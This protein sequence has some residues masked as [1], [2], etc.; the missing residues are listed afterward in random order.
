MTTSGQFS[1][2]TST[3]IVDAAVAVQVADASI[4]VVGPPCPSSCAQ[5]GAQCGVVADPRCG[6]SVDCGRCAMGVCGGQIPNVCSPLVTPAADAGAAI[7]I[8]D[9]QD[10]PSYIAVDANNIYWTTYSA[11]QGGSV[12]T[13]SLGGGVPVTLATGVLGRPG[14][15][16]LDA[17]SVYWTSNLDAVK[18]GVVMKV[19]IQGGPV[20]TLVTAQGS[21]F[22]GPTVD[23]DSIYWSE[24]IAGAVWRTSLDGSHLMTFASGQQAPGPLTH[25]A[26]NLYWESRGGIWSAPLQGGPPTQLGNMPVGPGFAISIAVDN[27]AVYSVPTAPLCSAWRTPI[28]GGNSGPLSFLGSGPPCI[29]IPIGRGVAVDTTSAYWTI[30]LRPGR[31][32][33]PNSSGMVL[34]APTPPSSMRLPQATTIADGQNVPWGIA[35]DAKRVYWTNYGG[36]NGGKGQVMIAPK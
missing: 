11:T 10:S 26:T 35:V 36:L 9:N 14:G 3:E 6:G 1:S 12:M 4:M 22:V 17:M 16:A 32:R 25:D 30:P 15:L 21:F 23:S 24:N 5:L 33:S 27:A 20:A 34:K 18:T 13:V 7:V 2:G 28:A 19:G 29:P 31:G 8:A